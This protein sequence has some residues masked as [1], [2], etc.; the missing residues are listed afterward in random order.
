MTPKHLWLLAITA[1]F[2]FAGCGSDANQEAEP[3]EPTIPSEPIE[4][5]TKCGNGIVDQGEDCDAGNKKSDGCK[6]DCKWALDD[7]ECAENDGQKTCISEKGSLQCSINSKGKMTC[8]GL[9]CGDG[10]VNGSEECDSLSPV[11]YGFDVNTGKALCD[12]TCHFTH[13]CGDGI[14][15]NE[16]E[17]CDNGTDNQDGLYGGCSKDCTK[18]AYCGDGEYDLENEFC[19]IGQNGEFKGCVECKS[20]E[21][22]YNCSLGWCAPL[23]CG[24]GILDYDEDCDDGNYDNN[25]GCS[26]CKID[27][28]YK[29]QHEIEVERVNDDG[30]FEKVTINAC[31]ECKSLDVACMPIA[32]GDGKLDADG[33][34][35]CDDG[36]TEPND[37]CTSGRIDP[38]YICTHPGHRCTAK[39]C[40]D[41][42]V[43]YGEECDDGN[44]ESDDGCSN[45]C[46]L[47]AGWYCAN[48]GT[49]CAKATCGNSILEGHEVC[50]DGNTESADGCSSNCLTIE[51][52]FRCPKSGGACETTTCGDGLING[53]S[54]DYNGAEE[55]DLGAS[56][57]PDSACN[58]SCIINNGWTCTDYADASTCSFGCCGDGIQ[59]KGEECDDGNN[60]A[61]DG[62]DPKCR[63]EGIFECLDGECK[64]IC[65]DGITLWMDTIPEEFREECDDG[66]LISG[67]GCSADCKIEPGFEC[68]KFS[69]EYTDTVELPI[70][71]YDFRRFTQS[72]NSSQGEYSGYIT[73]DTINNWKTEDPE[74]KTPMNNAK[75]NVHQGHPDFEQCVQ[76]EKSCRGMVRD[77]LDEDGKPVLNSTSAMCHNGYAVGTHVRCGA[78][79]HW[80][81]REAW[82]PANPNISYLSQPTH[83]NNVIKST[84]LLEHVTGDGIADGTYVFD[85]NNPPA[86]AKRVD[87]QPFTQGYFGPLDN[88]G[89]G[90]TYNN[91]HNGNFTSELETYFQYKGGEHLEFRGDDDVW[92]FVNSHLFVDLGGLQ[93]GVEGDGTLGTDEYVFTCGEQQ[94]S[95]G[96]HYDSNL[97]IYEGGIYP[98]KL[99]QAERCD[100]GSN[101]KLTLSGFL[102]TGKSTC[103]VACGDGKKS[104]NEECDN[105]ENNNDTLYNGCTTQCKRGPHCGDGVLDAEHEAC[106]DGNLAD[107]DGCTST[108]QLEIN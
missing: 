10:I 73:Q 26:N 70:T 79:Y 53:G 94:I 37:G 15:D 38:G 87:G 48:P 50:D 13:Y 24:N 31:T 41:G 5:E 107:G 39:T 71:Y 23:S 19:E 8:T 28:G 57:G 64:P 101:Y 18:N 2:C 3:S 82:N 36:N 54:N 106:D 30:I 58:T 85:S 20:A 61:G 96:R 67:D 40:G 74:C 88:S 43:A 11:E 29:C 60:K 75:I 76:S 62:C 47:E 100:S 66:N 81:Y 14:L 46:K 55:C 93:S 16:Y 77:T 7:F 104:E 69:T 89:Y 86:E 103:H 51:T 108:C 45:R 91:T 27:T 35:E 95:T 4:P 83:I 59:Q 25:D 98:I 97:D 63:R 80:W 22:G 6:S 78:T 68:T 84:L 105:G 65:G 1:T 99:F 102:N 17:E 33:Y 90:N 21:V 42:I 49:P 72:Y 56:N 92:V 34:E 52:G 32:Y 9:K 44:M 12:K